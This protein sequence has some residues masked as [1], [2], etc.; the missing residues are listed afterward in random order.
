MKTPSTPEGTSTP[1]R[2][3]EEVLIVAISF[4]VLAV[5]LLAAVV[6]L[7]WTSAIK[8]E[9]LI[10][11]VDQL[12]AGV[13]Q[14]TVLFHRALGRELLVQLPPSIA[15]EI[16]DIEQALADASRRPSTASA[17]N[18]LSARLNEAMDR[19]PPWG[20]EE[21]LPRVL[22]RRWEINALWLIA[23]EPPDEVDGILKFVKT[24]D[25]HISGRPPGSSEEIAQKL[26]ESNE[27]AKVRL[28][29]VERAE[30]IATANRA[31][32]SRKDMATALRLLE[33]YEDEDAKKL[34][35]QLNKGVLIASFNEAIDE[36]QAEL[37]SYEKLQ[38]AGQ[39][40]YAVARANQGVMDL[41][42]RTLAADISDADLNERLNGLEKK[43]AD[44]N[45][46]V[47]KALQAR[48]AERLTRYQVW[49]LSQIK[50]VRTLKE[51]E[52]LEMERISN[53]LDRNNPLSD[54]SKRARK[55]AMATL[56]NEMVERLAP[57]DQRWLDVAVSG[58]FQKVYQKRL[59]ELSEEEQIK[60]VEG[61]ANATKKSPE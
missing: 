58:W 48:D 30:A 32:K 40:E 50:Q 26:I 6:A 21:V 25:S 23:N 3:K 42:L 22:P 57:I 17:I 24:A 60:V 55:A 13:E 49:T 35:D 36:V 28:A 31:L 41:R 59:D 7:L 8:T 19:L 9:A 53:R 44:A 11:R 54:A 18:Q 1:T 37:K 43:I 47:R 34:A 15:S 4:R 5:A 29:K 39:R 33:T 38:D 61:F 10:A 20:Q 51:I 2:T 27:S 46:A 16:G 56:R 14:Q 12:S 52:A 45:S